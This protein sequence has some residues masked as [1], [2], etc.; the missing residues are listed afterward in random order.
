MLMGHQRVMKRQDAEEI[1]LRHVKAV[2]GQF[3]P[4]AQL[5]NKAYLDSVL[6]NAVP[7]AY[8]PK[9]QNTVYDVYVRRI[10]REQ[11]DFVNKLFDSTPGR[12]TVAGDGATVNSKHVIVWTCSKAKH[13]CFLGVRSRCVEQHA[14]E[15]E[16]DEAVKMIELAER[17]FSTK[18]A[19]IAVDN[20]STK[21][22]TLAAKK[23][24]LVPAVIIRDPSHSFDLIAKDLN[25]TRHNP[26][27]A[28]FL[29]DCREI[30]ATA[31][32]GTELWG[33]VQVWSAGAG[34]EL[35]PPPSGYSDTRMYGACQMLESIMGSMEA[36]MSVEDDEG[37]EEYRGK[38]AGTRGK[39]DKMYS[40]LE[41]VTFRQKLGVLLNVLHQVRLAVKLFVSGDTPYSAVYPIMHATYNGILLACGEDMKHIVDCFGE[42]CRDNLVKTLDARFNFSGDKP[43]GARVGVLDK[44]AIYAYMSDLHLCEPGA[45]NAPLL[46]N[47]LTHVV[48]MSRFFGGGEPEIE[49]Q[50]KA[51]DF[52]LCIGGGRYKDLIKKRGA[53]CGR[54][55]ITFE[56][57]QDYLLFFAAEFHIP[58]LFT[59][60]FF[61]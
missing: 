30:V 55:T 15:T 29:K 9:H 17:R 22:A 51:D 3:R 21:A 16:V 13:T 4:L 49:A 48:G 36:I 59:I 25:N 50:I 1:I 47:E 40:M 7:R 32:V 33:I 46:P 45:P 12:L 31:G 57:V 54:Y 34:A 27:I 61:K 58:N 24:G 41:A 35:P 56:L 42:P 23:A 28:E 39:I 44:A 8:I 38:S 53:A 43:S 19:A 2:L 11:M 18:V 14:T 37:L 10:H 52:Q 26:E 5:L 20:A 60:L 6:S